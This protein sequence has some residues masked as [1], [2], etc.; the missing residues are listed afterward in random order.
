MRHI[1]LLMSLVLIHQAQ[2][3][4]TQ[5]DIEGLMP[6][7]LNQMENKFVTKLQ[8]IAVRK[9]LIKHD[10]TIKTWTPLLT[11]HDE[12]ISTINEKIVNI[13]R[14]PGPTGATGQ[15]GDPGVIGNPGQPG[16]SGLPGARGGVGNPG[17]VGPRGLPGEKGDPGANGSQGPRGTQ[18]PS[19]KAGTPG[20]SGPVGLNGQSGPPGPP[21]PIGP[22][23][24]IGPIG[25][26]GP[27]G[28]Q[29]EQNVSVFTF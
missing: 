6:Y 14:T 15:K 9:T 22:M 10:N 19:G 2:S 16:S 26:I 29:R 20:T 3:T 28:I 17:A 13:Q 18:G 7:I 11:Y 12:Q 21:G 24:P 4:C 25:P 23:G 8:N 27:P 1:L 5:E